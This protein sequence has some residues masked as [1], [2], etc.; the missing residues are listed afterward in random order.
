MAP[1]TRSVKKSGQGKLVQFVFGIRITCARPGARFERWR[2]WAAGGHAQLAAGVNAATLKIGDEIV[3]L[4]RLSRKYPTVPRVNGQRSGRRMGYLGR[5][6]A[7]GW[8]NRFSSITFRR[9]DRN[10]LPTAHR[11]V[12]LIAITFLLGH[13]LPARRSPRRPLVA[14]WRRSTH[15]LLGFHGYRYIE[16]NGD[17]RKGIFETLPLNAEAAA[18]VRRWI[19]AR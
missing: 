4:G 9:H 2:R 8:I 13:R 14:G 11:P 7:N 6:T 1:R 19:R 10:W 15:R 3:I 12:A 17:A 5:K 16:M 18:S